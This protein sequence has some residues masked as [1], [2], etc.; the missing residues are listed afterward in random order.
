[1]NTNNKRP[2][3]ANHTHISIFILVSFIHLAL[4]TLVS[5]LK[6]EPLVGY[7]Y[8]IG[9]STVNPGS[10]LTC[11]LQLINKSSVFG[12]DIQNL[13]LVARSEKWTQ[14]VVIGSFVYWS[15]L[16]EACERVCI[17]VMGPYLRPHQRSLPALSKISLR[18]PSSCH[19]F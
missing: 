3:P 17:V 5:A 15:T 6:V 19:N 12:S 11:D 14:T 9:S 16:I 8:K 10:S 18:L 13:K 1:M 7:G 4:P 2:N